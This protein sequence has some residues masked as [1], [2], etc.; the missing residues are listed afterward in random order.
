MWTEKTMLRIP[1]PT[2]I[3][4][5]VV[6]AMGTPMIGHRSGAFSNLL[7]QVSEELKPIFGTK[8]NVYIL[9][10][11]GTSGLETAVVN[12]I[13]PGEEVAVIVTGSFGDRFAK[14]NEKFGITTHRLDLEWGKACTPELLASFLD[15]HPQVSAV[16]A[17]YCETSTGVLNPVDQLAK[18]VKEKTDALFI[19]DGVSCL[20]AVPCKMDHW[21]IDVL[22]TG[23]QKALMLPPGLAFIAAS[24]KAWDKIESNP[25]PRF[26]LDMVAYRKNYE[27]ETSP[28]TPA[29][30]LIFGLREVLQMIKEEGLEEIVNRH[31]IMKEMT[32]AG[33]KALNL[34]LLA[35]DQYA[36]PTV[37]AIANCPR[38]DSEELRKILRTK[39]NLVLAGGQNHLKGKIFRIGHMGYCDASDVLITLSLIELALTQLNVSIELGKGV[40]AAQEVLLQYV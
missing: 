23:S 2:P 38:Y 27:K 39:H 24:Q 6:H 4:P 3:P 25:R 8:E 22:V 9:T 16:F 1:G 33:I 35:E 30:S 40:K 26:Y 21:G 13:A 20:G 10:G 19:V 12:A 14:I 11:S 37:T 31:E 18:V 28:Y 34:P 32:R 17:T 15:Q 7:V 5:R 36:S 29:V